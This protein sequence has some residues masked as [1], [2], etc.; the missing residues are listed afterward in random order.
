MFLYERIL[1]L[2]SAKLFF[3]FHRI[4]RL[5]NQCILTFYTYYSLGATQAKL[6]MQETVKITANKV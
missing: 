3:S 6:A 5:G 2:N 4:Y 1:L